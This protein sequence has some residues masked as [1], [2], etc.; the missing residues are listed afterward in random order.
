[1]IAIGKLVRTVGLKGELKLYP[2]SS[3]P[4]CYEGVSLII[5][6][7]TYLLEH[8]RMHKGMGFLQ[9]KG[10]NQLEDAEA[11]VGHEA[12]MDREDIELDEDE[13]LIADLI[14]LKVVTSEGEEL[15]TIREVLSPA[16]HDIYVVQGKDEI[17]IPA[18]A[19]FIQSIDLEIRVVTVRLIEGMR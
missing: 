15:G 14:G 12:F 11:L 18:V 13:Y 7:R 16:G 1:M 4:S 17:L 6:G 19:E 3:D 5:D 10:L 8:F 9:L 2:Y